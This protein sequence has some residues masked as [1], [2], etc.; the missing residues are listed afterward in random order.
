M[1][2]ISILVPCFNEQD[3]VRPL[4][5]AVR[6]IL[7]EKLASYDYEIVFIDNKSND[8]TRKILKD[9]CAEDSRVKAIFNKKNFGQFNSPYYGLCQTSGDCTILLCADFQDPVDLIPIMVHEWEKG[10]TVIS[11]IKT[12][13]KENKLMY[14]LRSLYYKTIKAMSDAQQIEHFT[15]FGLYDKSFIDILR[16]LNDPTPF[17]RGIVAEYAPDH[18]EIPYEQQRRKAGKSSNNFFSLFDAAMLSFTSYTK[19]GLRLATL[20]G[21]AISAISFLI[22]L[23]Y[24]VEKL[25]FWD[26]FVAGNAPILIGVF[27]LGGVQMLFIGFLGEYVMSINT[28]VIHR[29]LV[30][31]EARFNFQ[32]S[33]ELSDSKKIIQSR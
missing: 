12:S 21:F 29:P 6:K 24:L 15:G 27:F 19:G 33:E 10:H 31:E 20:G 17:L 25:L 26:Q 9:L 5:D 1:K 23:I 11:M 8:D 22:A 4:C 2:K 30:I 18:L 14:W 16:T 32:E 3:N 7:Y 28:R 13:S